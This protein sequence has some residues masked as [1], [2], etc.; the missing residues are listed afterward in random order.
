MPVSGNKAAPDY[1]SSLSSR[2]VT[3]LSELERDRVT[4]LAIDEAWRR[5]GPAAAK[6]I[7][8]LSRKGALQRISRGFYVRIP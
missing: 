8:S 4:S 5:V 2:E 3:L 6:V 1:T 7:S